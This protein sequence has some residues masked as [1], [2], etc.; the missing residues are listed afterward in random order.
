[1]IHDANLPAVVQARMENN[2]SPVSGPCNGILDDGEP[3]N[4]S[5]MSLEILDYSSEGDSARLK[6]GRHNI[7]GNYRIYSDKSPPCKSG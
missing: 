3:N 7:P 6:R 5:E 1:M 2:K 4:S